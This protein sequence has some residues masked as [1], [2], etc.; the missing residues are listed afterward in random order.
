M[1][2]HDQFNPSQTTLVRRRRTY[3]A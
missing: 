1:L 2:H 3:G